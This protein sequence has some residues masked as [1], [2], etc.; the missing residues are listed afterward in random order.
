MLHCRPRLR[1]AEPCNC[2]HPLSRSRLFLKSGAACTRAYACDRAVDLNLG[3]RKYICMVNVV[4]NSYTRIYIYTKVRVCI[5]PRAHVHST[6]IFQPPRYT[7]AHS[8][9]TGPVIRRTDDCSVD[10]RAAQSTAAMQNTSRRVAPLSQGHREEREN[11]YKQGYLF[12]HRACPPPAA[13]QSEPLASPLL[14][15]PLL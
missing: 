12:I 9:A 3:M 6:T 8:A 10:S 11:T 1:T 13:A 14:A 7:R 5:Y 4:I 2:R 15:S